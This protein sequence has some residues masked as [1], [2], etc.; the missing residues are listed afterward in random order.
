MTNAHKGSKAPEAKKNTIK[1]DNKYG[2]HVLFQK[3]IN[4]VMQD[5]KQT[6]AERICYV[7]MD[8]LAEQVKQA[9]MDVFTKIIQNVRPTKSTKNRKVGG[10]NYA[11]PVEIHQEQGEK[12]AV[13][14]IVQEMRNIKKKSSLSSDEILFKILEDS[15]NNTGVVVQAKNAKHQMAESNMA[16]AHFRW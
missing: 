5:G 16:F 14:M 11:V 2:D 13:K 10:S 15:Y 12:L 9:P 4:N 3:L 1:A 8:K 7:A 6:I